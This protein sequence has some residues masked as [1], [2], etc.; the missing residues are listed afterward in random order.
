ME[1]GQVVAPNLVLARKALSDFLNAQAVPFPLAYFA[2]SRQEAGRKGPPFQE[3]SGGFPAAFQ[4]RAPGY[5]RSP[6]RRALRATKRP[7]RA[8]A[9]GAAVPA[10]PGSAMAPAYSLPMAHEIESDAHGA[11]A[12]R[13]AIAAKASMLISVSA[14]RRASI[15]MA[16]SRRPVMAAKAWGSCPKR[17]SFSWKHWGTP[18]LSGQ[19]GSAEYRT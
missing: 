1:T 14:S 8:P 18:C 3:D 16:R 13:H 17:S 15:P 2:Q 11:A 9:Q 4:I 6:C 12:P 7:G 19:P 5:Q 10:G